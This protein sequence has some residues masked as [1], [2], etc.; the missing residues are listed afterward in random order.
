MQFELQECLGY[1]RHPSYPPNRRDQTWPKAWIHLAL[2]ELCL[3]ERLEGAMFPTPT[4]NNLQI[5]SKAD[6]IASLA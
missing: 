2:H 1:N 4:E 3:A 6:K 5:P